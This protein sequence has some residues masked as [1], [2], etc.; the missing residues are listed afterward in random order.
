MVG[1]GLSLVVSFWSQSFGDVSHYVCS[2][3]F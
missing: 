3:Y 1:L 2:L